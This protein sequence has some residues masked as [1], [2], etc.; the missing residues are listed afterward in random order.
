ML[1]TVVQQQLT[2]KENHFISLAG[3]L[4]KA[5]QEPQLLKE[6]PVEAR[7]LEAEKKRDA[8]IDYHPTSPS[9]A[10]VKTIMLAANLKVY[11]T[12]RWWRDRWEWNLLPLAHGWD[13]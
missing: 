2:E 1:K 11:K 12:I 6:G 13:T 9:E 4:L 3:I 5:I 8:G 10:N 7:S